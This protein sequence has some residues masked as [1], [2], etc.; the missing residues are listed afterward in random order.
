MKSGS[1]RGKRTSVEYMDVNVF[2][3][4]NM[5][6]APCTDWIPACVSDTVPAKQSPT[7]TAR[8]C[9]HKLCHLNL[10]ETCPFSQNRGLAKTV[11]T[12]INRRADDLVP[13]EI[14]AVYSGRCFTLKMEARHSSKTSLNIYQSIRRHI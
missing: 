2:S 5:N 6:R 12:D 11:F 7:I 13:S 8:A 1:S 3:V 9:G 4:T 14:D 10:T